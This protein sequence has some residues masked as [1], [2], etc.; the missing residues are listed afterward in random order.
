M[1]VPI[2]WSLSALV[3]TDAQIKIVVSVKVDTI[4]VDWT[5]DF[6]LSRRKSLFGARAVLLS[7]DDSVERVEELLGEV[8]RLR[9]EGGTR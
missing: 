1:K 9:D 5:G 4:G 8:R 7:R 3:N 6:L 2:N